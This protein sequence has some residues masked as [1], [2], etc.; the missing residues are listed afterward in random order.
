MTSMFKDLG[1]FPKD[2]TLYEAALTHRSYVNQHKLPKK[3]DLQER[4][5][6]F[7]DAVLKFVVSHYLMQTFPHLEEGK[8]TKIRARIISD[9]SLATIGKS[10]NVHQHVRVSDSERAVHG[11][12]RDA[13]LA[14]VM[15]ALLGAMCLDQSMEACFDWFKGIIETYMVHLL[16]INHIVDYKTY[17]QELVQSQGNP[18]PNYELKKTIGPEHDKQF[19]VEVSVIFNDQPFSAIGIGRTKKYAQQQAATHCVELIKNNPSNQ[20]NPIG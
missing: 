18:L 10:L 20:I 9:R 1:I 7:G 8:L 19:S 4:L 17:L 16:D 5:E 14:N 6:F 2:K 13:L 12:K 15:E 3:E 11:H